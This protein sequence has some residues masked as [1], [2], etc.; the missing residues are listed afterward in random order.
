MYVLIGGMPAVIQMS[1]V[2]ILPLY[3]VHRLN[4]NLVQVLAVGLVWYNLK[5]IIQGVT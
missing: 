1:D 5:V 4:N 2:G 3:A